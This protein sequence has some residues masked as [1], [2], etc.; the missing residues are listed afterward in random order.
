MPAKWVGK[1]AKPAP[2]VSLAKPVF[3]N[4]TDQANKGLL[5]DGKYK[6]GNGLVFSPTDT[7]ATWASIDVGTGY[8]KLLL[9]WKDIG[10][11]D[12][13]A[14]TEAGSAT[15]YSVASGMFPTGY[16]IKTSSDSTDGDDGTWTT[17]VTVTDNA[18]P[19]RSHVIDFAGL[20][21]VRFEVTATYPVSTGQWRVARIDE[22]ELHDISAIGPGDLTDSWFI[23]GDS[24]T[25][26]TFDRAR[27]AGEFDKVIAAQ[28]PAYHPAEIGAGIGYEKLSDALRHLQS[29]AW[30]KNSE[31]LN[32]VTLAYGTN[33][34][35][36]GT[37]PTAAGYETTMRAIIKILTDAGRV[38]VLARI[39]WNTVS[40]SVP[41]FNAVIDMLQ[42][43]FELPCGPDLYSVVAAHPEYVG[44][45]GTVQPNCTVKYAGND[46]VHPQTSAAK[47]AIQAAYAEAVLP[48]YPTP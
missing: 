15:D 36:G 48:L 4:S 37:S 46:G 33:D 27:Q 21:W 23:M 6:N 25:K 35:W 8:T 5:V 28:R 1:L 30:L 43:E 16:L 11:S 47:N 42:Q 45:T 2:L 32:F 18:A 10:A 12:Y 39:P 41:Q 38:P 3:T 44:A 13:F 29:E 31:G 40:T 17:A 34:S 19:A 9:V 26:M 20:R 24:I 22:L 7:S 14:P